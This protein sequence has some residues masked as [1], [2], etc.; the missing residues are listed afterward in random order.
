MLSCL[1]STAEQVTVWRSSFLLK[2]Q[3]VDAVGLILLEWI[4]IDFNSQH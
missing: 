2:K 1:L 3:M 4:Y